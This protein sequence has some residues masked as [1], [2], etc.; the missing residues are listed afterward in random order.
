M[1]PA[2]IVFSCYLLIS[3]SGSRYG[4]LKKVRVNQTVSYKRTRLIYINFFS[5]DFN[6]CNNFNTFALHWSKINLKS[7]LTQLT[8]KNEIS[9]L[10]RYIITFS[11]VQR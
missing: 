2:V 11:R 10:P 7:I 3:C 8:G 6:T 4:Y 1:K 5:S 9:P